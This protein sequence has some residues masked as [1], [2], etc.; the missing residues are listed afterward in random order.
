MSPRRLSLFA[1]A[2]VILGGAVAI[3]NPAALLPNPIAQ[4][5]AS[6]NPA[7][8]DKPAQSDMKDS[9]LKELNL[10][11]GQVQ[12]IQAIRSQYRNR[13]VQLRQEL[14]QAQQELRRLMAGD[15]S[16]DQVRQ[17]Y[18][19]VKTLRQL[20]ADAQFESMLA[21]REL[22]NPEQRQKFADRMKKQREFKDR[23]TQRSPDSPQI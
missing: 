8:S 7:Q 14:R 5:P 9:W 10:T 4:V 22:L 18:R 23:H 21:T 3:A 6:P 19:R 15:A 12:K 2:I 1:A 20:L 13:I 17:Q 11:P 16:A